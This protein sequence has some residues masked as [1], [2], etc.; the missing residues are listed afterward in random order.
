[1][2]L[3]GTIRNQ[4]GWL[5][6]ALIF[7][8]I[9]AFL[10]MDISPGNTAGMGGAV[11]VGYVNDD[12]IT[13]EMIRA[14]SDEYKGAGYLNE[15]IQEQVWDRLVGEKLL[16]QKTNEAG[17][18]VTPEEMG[19]M[20]L[21]DRPELLS[22]IVRNRFADRQTGQVNTAQLKQQ[23]DQIKNTNALLENAQNENDRQELLEVQKQWFAMER[24]VKVDRLQ[25]KYFQALNAGFYAPNWMTEFENNLQ[26]ATYSIDYVRIPYTNITGNI[27]VTDEDL[28]SYI[29][30]RPKQY[31]RKASVNIEYVI[32]PVTPTAQDSAQFREE[33]TQV[34]NE[35]RAASTMKDDSMIVLRNYGQFVTTYYTRDELPLPLGMAD[36]VME[37]TDGTIFG[38]Y[39]DKQ[40]Y[41]ILKKI[42]TK[43]LADSVRSRHIL[44]RA[45]NPQEGQNA[46]KLLDSLKNVLLTDPTASFDSLAAQYSTDGSR[47]Q[48][49]DL[50][51]KAKDGSFVA[52]FEEYMFYTGEKDSLEIIYTQFGVHL[53]QITDEKYETDKKGVRVAMVSRDIIPS[54]NTTS[55]R[56]NEVL[57]FI[58]TNRSLED[59]KADARERGLNVV[60][61][62]GL[63]KRGYDIPGIGKN[64]TSADIIQWAHSKITEEGEV[65]ANTYSVENEEF[66]YTE[67]FVVPVL[68]KRS[69]AGL[70]TLDDPDV[71]A[72]VDRAV[73][74][75]KKVE[76]VREQ[77]KNAT[78]LDAI[79]GQYDVTRASAPSVIYKA[80]SLGGLG[81][82]PKVAA[83]A[84]STEIGQ[85]SRVVGGNE[86]V[87]IIQVQSKSDAAPIS[88]L[89]S[90]RKE[91]MSRLSGPIS[92]S[93]YNEMKE[94]ADIVDERPEE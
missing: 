8:A 22:P 46:R 24:S 4:F 38:P 87:Y 81:N 92:S 45:Q 47:F 21:S 19:D 78:S 60:P 55:A 39:V 48:G 1:M 41:K 15:E 33:L 11:T 28:K 66:N 63:Q 73:R 3:L 94:N 71:R 84:A 65:A 70:A 36:T 67:S 83:L 88:N 62:N 90:A 76:L 53:I 69:P 6:M 59:M 5:M 42:E 7:I 79:A 27:T 68:I 13:N 58:T 20:F 75:Q 26:N 10:F 40:Q 34:A 23:M 51:W 44:I 17:M 91:V 12:K 14:Y 31:D 74:N 32:F 57:D 86:G 61:A 29:A 30:A 9:A 89:S 37:A 56:Q 93:I 72:E 54:A 52:P 49:G 43:R 85:V 64:T 35:L 18:V 2:A 16:L 82:E 25:G 80:A 50:G 77:V